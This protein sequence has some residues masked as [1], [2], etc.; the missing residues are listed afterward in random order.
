[1]DISTPS[2]HNSTK[3]DETLLDPTVL[4]NIKQDLSG[5]GESF[6]R[7]SSQGFVKTG[8]DET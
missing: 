2:F 5:G 4:D 6:P 3:R 8:Q 7:N 1:M